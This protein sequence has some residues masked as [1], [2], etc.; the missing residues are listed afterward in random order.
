MEGSATACGNGG[1]CPKE[2][3]L[4]PLKAWAWIAK[5]LQRIEDGD[6]WPEGTLGARAILLLKEG[7]SGEEMGHYR[8]LLMLS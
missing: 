6:Q 5:L 7:N 1:V 4:F 2:T 8:I 3:N